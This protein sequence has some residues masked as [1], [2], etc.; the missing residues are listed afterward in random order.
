MDHAV[1][2]SPVWWL[3]LLAM[4]FVAAVNAIIRPETTTLLN[5]QV[6]GSVRATVMSAQSLA[7]TIYIALLHPAVGAAADAWSTAGAFAFL[8]FLCVVPALFAISLRA[9]A[10]PSTDPMATRQA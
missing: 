4:V 7:M 1:A 3:T 6:S 9:I 8:A 2:A 5:R 10:A